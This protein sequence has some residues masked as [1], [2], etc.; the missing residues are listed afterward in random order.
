MQRRS[1]YGYRRRK[2]IKDRF[3]AKLVKTSTGAAGVA[4]LSLFFIFCYDAVTQ[5]RYFALREIRVS[6]ADRIGEDRIIRQAAL[7]PGMNILAVNLSAV[8]KRLLAHP[9]VSEAAIQRV[10]PSGLRISVQEHRPLAIIDL[11]RR[12][13]I[14]ENGEI[15]KELEPG[16]PMDLPVIAGLAYTDLH[17]GPAPRL[18]AL[19]SSEAIAATPFAKST[20]HS[21]NYRAAV[22]VLQLARR[23]AA[24]LPDGHIRSVQVDREIGVTIHTFDRTQTIRMGFSDYARKLD[25][26]QSILAFTR[27]RDAWRLGEPKSIDLKNPDRV[28]VNLIR[29]K[30]V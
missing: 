26:L 21:A 5:C 24:V 25:V 12:F 1:K 16:D 13:L 29:K 2:R 30:E 28:V 19:R 17:F 4:L 14:D 20:A 9:W 10:I 27:D 11:G 3:P 8:R 22:S 15:F 6:G 18:P 23:H 7:G